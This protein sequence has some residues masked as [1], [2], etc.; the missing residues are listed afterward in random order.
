MSEINPALTAEEW[1]HPSNATQLGHACNEVFVGEGDTL[2]TV[3][4]HGLA[5]LCLYGKPFGFT[6]EDVEILR[7]LGSIDFDGLCMDDY[8][9]RPG[10]EARVKSLADRIAALLPPVTP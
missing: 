5:A 9:G 3:T 4:R 1:A 10:S 8:L 2:D 6:A 7:L